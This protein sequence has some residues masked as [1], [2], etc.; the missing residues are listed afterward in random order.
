[1]AV[2]FRN[3]YD[4]SMP[5]DPNFQNVYDDTNPDEAPRD[6]SGGYAVANNGN[7]DV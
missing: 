7:L 6:E 2:K 4:P 1:M 3:I 5:F